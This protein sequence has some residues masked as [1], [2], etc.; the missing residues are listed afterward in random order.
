M[1]EIKLLSLKKQNME[2]YEGSTINNRY[3]VLE[4]KGKGA[5]AKVYLVEKQEN[6]KNMQQK[7]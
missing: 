7:Y 1:I 5:S 2:S 4:T 6:K 3:N